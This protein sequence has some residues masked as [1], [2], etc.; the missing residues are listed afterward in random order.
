MIAPD[1]I[2]LLEEHSATL[3]LWWD[4]HAG[5]G[6]VVY[7]DA[8]LDL[9]PTPAAAMDRLRACKSI[10][11]VRKLESP[12]YLNP[13]IEFAFGIENFLYAAHETGLIERL[14]WVAPPHV[15]RHYS[16]ALV[17]YMQQ[18]DGISFDEL[19]GF[20]SLGHNAIRG[21]LLGLDIT[22]CD[23]DKLHYLELAGDYSLD[24]DIDYFVEVPS[25]RLWIDPARVI[26]TIRT[27]LGDPGLVTISRAVSSGF[28]P[29]AFRFVGDYLFALLQDRRD[30]YH[31][32]SKI[33]AAI[34]KLEQDEFEQGEMICQQLTDARPELAAACYLLALCS[35]DALE[36]KRLL[37]LAC[38]R[39]PAYGFNVAREA[40]GLMNRRKTVD[41][42][43]LVALV[44]SLEQ[45]PAD[46]AERVLAEVALASLLASTGDSEQA[47]ELL[48]RQSGAMADHDD[49]L[50]AIVQNQ[51]GNTRL[52]A[53]NAALLDRIGADSKNATAALLCR[54]D[55]A[56]AHQDYESA[57]MNYT[58]AHAR[59]EAWLL[60]LQGM[61]ASCENLKLQQQAAELKRQ[62]ETR[63]QRLDSILMET[64]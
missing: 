3:P 14:I 9:Q 2:H 51:L 53:D 10:D 57:L 63:Q 56:F 36:K 58:K 23:Y 30:D 19:T 44:N 37:E 6:V 32:Y 43:S 50:L 62:I 60:P 29:M 59:A 22:I 17:D 8:H 25:D 15:P 34:Q 55:L 52:Y 41:Q 31:Y 16:Q 11:E 1:K 18:L 47:V 20:R 28:T 7:L 40:G 45:L 48:A 35:R 33:F 64:R 4:N 27:Q 26:D 61:L 39:D 13:A 49:V 5:P 42:N 24:I 46:G 38:A 54:A 12:H 21:Q